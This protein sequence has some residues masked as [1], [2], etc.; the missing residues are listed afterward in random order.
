MSRQGRVADRETLTARLLT[1]ALVAVAV[2]GGLATWW[3]ASY[4]PE[5]RVCA[6]VLPPPEACLTVHRERRAVYWIAALGVVSAAAVLTVRRG[7]LRGRRVSWSALALEL[8]V[9]AAA[10][11]AVRP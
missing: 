8:A 6:A 5:G 4:L 7:T 3:L 1:V 9:I 2:T 10:L 11:L